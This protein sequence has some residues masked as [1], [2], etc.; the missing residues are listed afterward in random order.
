MIWE[1]GKSF[2]S[3]TIGFTIAGAK[4][5]AMRVSFTGELGWELHVAH[6]DARAVYDA[7]MEAGAQQNIKP[8]GMLALDSMRLEKG[9]RSW[10]GDLTSDYDMYDAG[11]AR[12]VHLS[13]DSF[14]G[15]AALTARAN[16][17]RRQFV[18]LSVDDPDDSP[19]FGEAIYLSSVMQKDKPEEGFGATEPLLK[20]AYVTR[21]FY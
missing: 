12:W 11:L 13:K 1:G 17:P 5:C 2:T 7:V 10:K 21:D 9:Y 15:K 14:V 3:A 18:T 19:D 4:I 16:G 8:F 20:Y 6:D